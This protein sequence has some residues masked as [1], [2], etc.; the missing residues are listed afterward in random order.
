MDTL[1][2]INRLKRKGGENFENLTPG[3]VSALYGALWSLRMYA[4]LGDIAIKEDI[5]KIWEELS[6]AEV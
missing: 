5:N 1:D 2:Y 4:A 3:Q 6:K